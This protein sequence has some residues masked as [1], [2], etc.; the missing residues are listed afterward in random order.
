[1]ACTLKVVVPGRVVVA[2]VVIVRI[3]FCE[4]AVEAET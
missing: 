4:A 1:V 2:L 3:E